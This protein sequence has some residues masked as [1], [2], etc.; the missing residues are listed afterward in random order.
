MK[1]KGAVRFELFASQ[2][3][4]INVSR[5]VS[6]QFVLHFLESFDE[7]AKTRVRAAQSGRPQSLDVCTK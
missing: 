3:Q 4:I 7:L 1:K 5:S 2:F 6:A